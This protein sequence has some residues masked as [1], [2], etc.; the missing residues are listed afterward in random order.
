MLWRRLVRVFMGPEEPEAVGEMDNTSAQA[1]LAGSATAILEVPEKETIGDRGESEDHPWFAPEGVTAVEPPPL[2]RPYLSPEGRILENLLIEQF[3]GHD[4]SLPPLPRVPDLVLK[5]LRSP[6]CRFE[7]IARIISEDQVIAASVLRAANSPLYRGRYK[8]TSPS[9]AV[10]RL[11]AK[12]LQML[13]MH[14]SLRAATFL[15]GKGNQELARMFWRRSLAGSWIMRELAA[16]TGVDQE[17]AL[18]TGLL[19]DVGNVVILRVISEDNLGM[20]LPDLDTFEYICHETH[21]EFGELVAAE[22]N[23]A[24]HLKAVIQEHHRYP[25]LAD[26]F[27]TTRLQV[28]LTDMI[29]AML[30]YGQ[31]AAYDLLHCRPVQDLKLADREDFIAFLT[32]LP[33]RIDESIEWF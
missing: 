9:Q 16:F 25:D 19:H 6:A 13:M 11:G 27:R 17:D 29:A 33:Q 32:E 15:G 8:I 14:Q 4:L 7:H 23:M 31:P 3:D 20:P 30:G 5:E 28:I 2:V 24:P 22:W 12:A 1:D 10:T 18:V 21:Q 26:P